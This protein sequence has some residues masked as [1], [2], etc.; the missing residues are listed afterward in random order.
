MKGL[1]DRLMDWWRSLDR[2]QKPLWAAGGAML[3]LLVVGAAFFAGKP[4]MSMLFGGLAPADQG[5]VVEELS[6][7]GIRAEAD[8]SGNVFVA[9]NKVAEARMRL[10]TAKKLPNTGTSGMAILDGLGMTTSPTVEREKVRIALENDLS[11][12]I[13]TMAGISNA[14][15]HLTLGEDSPFLRE[16]KPATASVILTEDGGQRLRPEQSEGIA[17]LIQYSVQGLTADRIAIS[18]DK[19]ELLFDGANA[20]GASG[21][22]DKRL[23]T[24]IEEARRRERDLQAKLDSAFGAGN[25]VVS[26]PVLKLNFDKEKTYKLER[27]P[28]RKPTVKEKVSE[29]MSDEAKREEGSSGSERNIIAD[30][31]S[32]GADNRAYKGEN[33]REEYV[34]NETERQIE[35]AAGDLM[36][37]S[38]NV[39]V[40]SAKIQDAAPVEQ[41]VA[42]YLGPLTNDPTNFKSNVT[43]V[44][45]DET[46]SKVAAT[47]NAAA[48]SRDRMQQLISLAPIA[49]LLIVG[50]MVIKALGKTAKSFA[51]PENQMAVALP[52]GG[53]MPLPSSAVEEV[54]SD[55]KVQALPEVVRMQMTPEQVIEFQQTGEL[56][57]SL[58]QLAA[59]MSSNRT[60]L[61]IEA[62]PEKVH[63]PLEQLKAMAE[64]KPEAV[65]GL[66]KTW[67]LE[68]RK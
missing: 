48:A 9:S 49:A 15:I 52:G 21:I 2:S 57:E 6:K 64:T 38:V 11:N 37:M 19:G 34:V 58:R 67:I 47:A 63:V 35:K 62:I 51:P 23:Q 24:E 25:T 28:S 36:S 59:T 56:A 44:A 32:S 41:Y 33:L 26:I 27:D 53:S 5:M 30:G 40:N 3:V 22:A 45:F 20:S 43:T 29:T 13:K 55:P 66:L 46:A 68:E 8:T 39:L 16:T 12:S 54:F 61:E 10:A 17:R 7:L 14:R 60:Q 65:A 31:A 42:G 4:Q 50:F 1:L 18:N